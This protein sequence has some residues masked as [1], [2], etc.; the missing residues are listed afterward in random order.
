M[1][2]KNKEIIF[3][4]PNLL[5]ALR[6][7]FS[8]LLAYSIFEL[9]SIFSAL[10]FIALALTDLFDGIAARKL[11]QKT[12][13][14]KVFDPFADKILLLAVV[15]PIIIKY[16]FYFILLIFSKEIMGV[17]LLLAL[18][19]N[20]KLMSYKPV[21]I[22]KITTFVQCVTI[23]SVLLNFNYYFNLFLIIITFIL[24]L[25]AGFIYLKMA[26]ELKK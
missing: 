4:I 16:K 6:I 22:G 25:I 26:L 10:L 9:Q 2:K 18:L 7:L 15:L 1:L 8:P 17:V 13:F 19:K 24:G 11:N 23:A 20:K 3:N 14:G 5:S 21:F 12:E